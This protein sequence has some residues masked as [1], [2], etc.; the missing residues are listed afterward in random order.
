VRNAVNKDAKG[1]MM[2][3]RG[4]VASLFRVGNSVLLNENVNAIFGLICDACD[5]VT[6]AH[7]ERAD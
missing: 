4:R 5:H 3:V 1:V 7:D 6:L 2:A